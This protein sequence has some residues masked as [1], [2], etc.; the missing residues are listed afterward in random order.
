MPAPPTPGPTCSSAVRKATS[1]MTESQFSL[2][3]EPRKSGPPARPSSP[4]LP[5]PSALSNGPGRHRADVAQFVRCV[6]VAA[7]LERATAE[8]VAAEAHRDAAEDG[9]RVE[10]VS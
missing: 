1:S 3:F 4:Q 5:S 7:L 8:D 6:V 9:Q 10:D 2:K